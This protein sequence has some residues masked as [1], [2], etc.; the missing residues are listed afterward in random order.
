MKCSPMPQSKEKSPCFHISISPE[1]KE[2]ASTQATRA[3]RC[4]SI[5]IIPHTYFPHPPTRSGI[6]K[7]MENVL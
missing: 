1:N 4:L 5:S 2:Y 6:N 7:K 3:F